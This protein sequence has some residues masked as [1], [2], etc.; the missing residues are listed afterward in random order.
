MMR[1]RQRQ[2]TS[3]RQPLKLP[4]RSGATCQEQ[5]SSRLSGGGRLK[6]EV[7]SR[8]RLVRFKR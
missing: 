1:D 2:P 4:A 7:D 3:V 8:M 5:D 6:H